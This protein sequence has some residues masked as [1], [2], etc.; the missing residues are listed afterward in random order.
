MPAFIGGGFLPASA[1]RKHLTGY[2]HAADWYP[3]FC[4]LAG[5][6]DCTEEKS[7]GVLQKLVPAIDGHNMLPYIVGDAAASPRT[8]IMLDSSCYDVRVPR[9]V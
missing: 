7:P 6:A 8:E 9:G 1:R 4:M 3:T 5:G 2:I